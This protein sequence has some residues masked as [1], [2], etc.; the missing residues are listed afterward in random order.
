MNVLIKILQVIFNPLSLIQKS[1]QSNEEADFLSR[2][3][4][5]IVSIAILVTAVIMLLV[6]FVFK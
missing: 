3:P 4:Y 1:K 2:F 6:H 5:V